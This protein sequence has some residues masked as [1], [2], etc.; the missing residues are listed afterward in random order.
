MDDDESI[1]AALII[2]AKGMMLRNA[3]HNEQTALDQYSE[4]K[5]RLENIHTPSTFTGENAFNV[6]PKIRELYVDT[7]KGIATALSHCKVRIGSVLQL[8][9]VCDT[10]AE[11]LLL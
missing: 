5:L 11:C 1:A 2:D 3:S 9:C 10:P 8:C 6:E 4:A 7:L